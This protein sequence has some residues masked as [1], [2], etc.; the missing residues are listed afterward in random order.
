MSL[1]N[2]DRLAADAAVRPFAAWEPWQREMAGLAVLHR[3]AVQGQ[4]LPAAAGDAALAYLPPLLDELRGKGLI[5]AQ[6]GA[7]GWSVTEK[8]G[9][10]L[11]G[12]MAIYD[13]LLKF[14]IF[15]KV[16]ITRALGPDEANPEA[17]ATVYDNLYDPRFGDP[18]ADDGGSGSPWEDLRLAVMTFLQEKGGDTPGPAI[19]PRRV[20][21][22]QRYGAGLLRAPAFWQDLG[23]GRVFADT[24][25]IART[26]I[27]WRDVA[28]AEDDAAAAMRAIYTAGMLEQRKRDGRECGSCGTPLAIYEA[29]AADEGRAL[30]ACPNP[31]C[32]ASF[33]P[34]PAASPG[35]P[36][37]ECPRCHATIYPGQSVCRCGALIDASLPPGTVAEETIEETTEETVP[38]WSGF[39][40]GYYDPLFVPYGYYDPWAWTVTDALAFGVVCALLF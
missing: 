29:I 18:A 16:D 1:P 15:S 27:A 19:D 10:A 7:P 25:E 4:P 6:P 37:L 35:E 39:W 8:G 14:E 32:G 22:V 30:D 17:P 9:D 3:L 2:Q 33:G 13:H 24:E 36:E 20:V 28:E 34:P 12:A 5:A 11:R 21:L 31:N 38:T 26:A 23:S 40:G